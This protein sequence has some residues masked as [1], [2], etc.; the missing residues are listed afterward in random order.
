M[1]PLRCWLNLLHEKQHYRQG[2][3]LKYSIEEK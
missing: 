3:D 1:L 2:D